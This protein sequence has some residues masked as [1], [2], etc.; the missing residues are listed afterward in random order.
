M[1]KFEDLCRKL[2]IKCNDENTRQYMLTYVRDVDIDDLD[3]LQSENKYKSDSITYTDIRDSIR[4]I[5]RYEWNA[6]KVLYIAFCLAQLGDK[7]NFYFL[8]ELQE[9]K[10][11]LKGGKLNGILYDRC[12]GPGLRFLDNMRLSDDLYIADVCSPSDSSSDN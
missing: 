3:L 7:R 4:K 10:R 5:S 1:G 2:Y 11:I 6:D 12:I 9:V 8:L